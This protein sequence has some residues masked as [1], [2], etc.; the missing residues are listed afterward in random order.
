M[1]VDL[2]RL[3]EERDGRGVLTVEETF[4]VTDAFDKQHT[5]ECR[6]ELSWEC[7]GGAFFFHGDVAS[8]LQTQC[9]LCLEEVSAPLTGEFDVVVR[10]GGDRGARYEDHDGGSEE[11]RDLVTLSP[12][13]KEFSFDQYII[14]NLI[15]NVP[16]QIL[17]SQDCKGLCPQCGTNRNRSNCD[18]GEATDPSWDA[19]RKLKND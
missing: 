16:M 9:H 8:E 15:V 7:R 1:I 2:R 6:T 3:E 12:G 13:Q 19:L 18:C 17:C 14:E 5:V 11:A 4:T 10:K